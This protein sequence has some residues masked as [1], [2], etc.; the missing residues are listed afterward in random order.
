MEA[1][2]IE[3]LHARVKIR[4]TKEEQ[5]I[6]KKQELQMQSLLKRICRDR[7]EQVKHRK[8]DSTNLIQRNK[9]ILKDVTSKQGTERRRTKDFLKFAL[10]KRE[11]IN[12]EHKFKSVSSR[13]LIPTHPPIL[14]PKSI[15][16]AFSA[17]DNHS[18]YE[19]ED[20]TV[21]SFENTMSR[22]SNS[23]NQSPEQVQ[24]LSPTMDPPNIQDKRGSVLVSPK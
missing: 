22:A 23:Q 10:G 5:M 21:R 8:T 11:E 13:A 17:Q 14:K 15:M 1:D 6:R 2:E 3:Q 16:Q 20:G 19:Y 9:N 4:L 24:S 12:S 18:A 7:D